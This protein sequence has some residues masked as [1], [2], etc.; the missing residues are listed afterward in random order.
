MR[1]K[2]FSDYFEPFLKP[3]NIGTISNDVDDDRDFG[4]NFGL[5]LAVVL[6]DWREPQFRENFQN[7]FFDSFFVVIDSFDHS[8]AGV[9]RER[10]VFNF[11]TQ[12]AQD[13]DDA[14]AD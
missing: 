6:V 7:E 5:E 12:V 9:R 13:L 8:D 3:L 10:E 1:K 11:E 2:Y 4:E 14:L